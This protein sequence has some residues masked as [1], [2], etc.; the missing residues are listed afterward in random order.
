MTSLLPLRS[1][2][3]YRDE[4]L[5]FSGYLSREGEI[6]TL[7]NKSLTFPLCGLSDACFIICS[8]SE[9]PR[10]PQTDFLCTPIK[11]IFNY[12]I[13]PRKGPKETLQGP[14]DSAGIR[15]LSV[16]CQP[17]LKFWYS[18]VLPKIQNSK[19]RKKHLGNILRRSFVKVREKRKSQ[20][21]GRDPQGR[22][23]MGVSRR[24][25]PFAVNHSSR[26]QVGVPQGDSRNTEVLVAFETW[27][28][29]TREVI[30]RKT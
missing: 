21:E 26:C 13:T 17:W 3:C 20:W 10:E 6:Y 24:Q 11:S 29:K 19:E 9:E 28:R 18:Q 2:S 5:Y 12:S 8:A 14:R 7:L 23:E 22:Q 25:K 16:C 15:H 30:L 4:L 27:R 1:P